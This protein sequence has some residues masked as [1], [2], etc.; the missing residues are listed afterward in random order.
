M[1]NGD[2]LTFR[3]HGHCI[4]LDRFKKKCAQGSCAPEDHFTLRLE[5]SEDRAA[6]YEAQSS[7][8]KKGNFGNIRLV[9][10]KQLEAFGYEINHYI[11]SISDESL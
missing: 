4:G 10:P 9:G 2:N 1:P 3:P 7:D 6:K 11:V 8:W 5:L